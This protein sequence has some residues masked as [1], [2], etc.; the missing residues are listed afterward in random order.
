MS[1][2]LNVDIAS[3]MN[4]NVSM[5]KNSEKEN[6][7]LA[8]SEILSQVLE[9]N[10]EVIIREEEFVEEESVNSE[11]SEISDTENE[12]TKGEP[13]EQESVATQIPNP[14]INNDIHLEQSKTNTPP[15]NDSVEKVEMTVTRDEA[16]VKVN[17]HSIEDNSQLINSSEKENTQLSS[18][19]LTSGKELLTAFRVGN[20]PES[21][22]SYFNN[23]LVEIQGSQMTKSNE[24]DSS[25]ET[26]PSKINQSENSF[27]IKSELEYLINDMSV[28]EDL[29]EETVN[30]P[31][32]S[33]EAEI[34]QT[35]EKSVENKEILEMEQNSE[36]NR[37]IEDATS[38]ILNE[39][40]S[41]ESKEILKQVEA[42]TI[43]QFNSLSQRS[44]SS[45]TSET[46]TQVNQIGKQEFNSQNLPEI[47]TRI[48]EEMNT[49]NLTDKHSFKLTLKPES[50]GELNVFLEMKDGKLKAEFLVDNSSVKNLI[51]G[52]L[53]SLQ[54]TFGKSNIQ[55]E[56]IDV[57]LQSNHQNNSMF[58]GD[59]SQRQQDRQPLPKQNKVSQQYET[60]EE[61]D[62]EIIVVERDSINIL[63]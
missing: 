40:T 25:L 27:Q 26:S 8:F 20:G 21:K 47:M 33:K 32:L 50:L 1:N 53:L 7:N 55:V 3:L 4:Q 16:P 5:K 14:I 63:V 13:S 49:L 36:V 59:L 54:D 10:N 23:Q 18:S 30:R 2:N 35:N 56:K 19:F 43:F 51:E 45:T 62:E 46:I 44:I 41:D 42:D 57:T 12:T 24:L 17:S 15:D 38:D 28:E 58:G 37:E 52:N 22:Q 6:S 39:V 48:S 61:Y 60:T 31:F 9:E 29:L 34:S 11:E